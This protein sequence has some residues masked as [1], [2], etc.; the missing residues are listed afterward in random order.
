MRLLD[1]ARQQFRVSC[2]AVFSCRCA[3]PR[4]ALRLSVGLSIRSTGER[5][6]GVGEG[7][8]FATVCAPQ[9][10]CGLE[11]VISLS[12]SFNM[13][14]SGRCPQTFQRVPL[15]P[16]RNRQPMGVGWKGPAGAQSSET[17]FADVFVQ[18]AHGRTDSDTKPSPPR[19]LD[20]TV[21]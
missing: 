5:G 6:E 3:A 11:C 13:Q 18:L 19:C 9:S 15:M 2:R 1:S 10:D 14:L 16:I 17:Q 21:S 4:C 20:A 8:T 7:A 12:V